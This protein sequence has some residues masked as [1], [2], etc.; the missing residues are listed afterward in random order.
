MFKFTLF[1]HKMSIIHQ[2]SKSRGFHSSDEYL[3]KSTT[4]YSLKRHLNNSSVR[5]LPAEV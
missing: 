4:T 3:N 5:S 2:K 1:E